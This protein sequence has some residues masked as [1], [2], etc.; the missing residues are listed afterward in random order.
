MSK[1][2]FTSLAVFLCLVGSTLGFS[3]TGL[4][5]G[6][7]TRRAAIKDALGQVRRNLGSGFGEL[8]PLLTEDQLEQLKET[9]SVKLCADNFDPDPDVNKN[10]ILVNVN[11]GNKPT[12][13]WIRAEEP[14]FCLYI[15]TNYEEET[16]IEIIAVSIWGAVVP[17]N[18]Q[19]FGSEKLYVHATFNVTATYEQCYCASE[20]F[21][22]SP[23]KYGRINNK[24][25]YSKYSKRPEEDQ[26][27]LFCPSCEYCKKAA[28]EDDAPDPV[29]K[30]WVFF[31]GVTGQLWG[32][33]LPVF[34]EKIHD[35][36]SKI[37]PSIN[38]CTID[39]TN[40]RLSQF[41]CGGANS[42]NLYCGL[43][44]WFNCREDLAA[45]SPTGN[46]E[47]VT[48]HVADINLRV[49]PCPI[50]L[51]K[52]VTTAPECDELGGQFCCDVEI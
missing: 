10:H 28:K 13:Q 11:K 22:G 5:V 41:G 40:L 16:G 52:K 39:T 14:E 48:V 32:P 2:L 20:D 17:K 36:F 47:D 9:G 15:D 1:G 12:L 33:G 3:S 35:S 44:T 29:Y 19:K 43:G 24:C 49:V 4:S 21:A 42:K 50:D 18:E 34:R 25:T 23:P 46:P 51:C 37:D 27:L 31:Q 8:L 45:L 38:S 6:F 26:D 7:E 30:Y